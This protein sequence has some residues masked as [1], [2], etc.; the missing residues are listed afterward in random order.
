MEYFRTLPSEMKRNHFTNLNNG[1]TSCLVHFIRDGHISKDDQVR[2]LDRL[3][4]FNKAEYLF[5]KESIDTLLRMDVKHPVI[6]EN[7]ITFAEI[8]AGHQEAPLQGQNLFTGLYYEK[9]ILNYPVIF[10]SLS[11][12]SLKITENKE[13]ML[14]IKDK[15]SK[16]NEWANK[17]GC[18]SRIIT[19]G[20][21]KFY[22]TGET[23]GFSSII[24]DPDYIDTFF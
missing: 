23:Q 2:F 5:V 14:S 20:Y 15:L 4:E 9:L 3:H 10:Q 6:I 13:L 17:E 19:W 24:D 8:V 22:V 16:A 11:N 21:N 7:L 12:K 1:L 18:D